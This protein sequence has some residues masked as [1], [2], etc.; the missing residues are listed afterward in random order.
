MIRGELKRLFDYAMTAGLTTINPLIALPMRH[1]HRS[2]TRDRALAP[3]ETRVPLK[4]VM[5]SNVRRQ[6]KA[7]P[8]RVLLT[9]VRKSA[10]MRARSEHLDYEK[11]EWSIPAEHSK[12][13]KPHLVFLSPQALG[14]FAQLR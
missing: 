6:L 1:V 5:E 2:P 14:L 13:G 11:A 8:R 4:A 10:L 12:T 9:L 3:P 7:A